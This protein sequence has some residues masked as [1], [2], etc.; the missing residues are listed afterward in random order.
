MW[1]EGKISSRVSPRRA[2]GEDAR[3]DDASF[4]GIVNDRGSLEIRAMQS[5]ERE[6]CSVSVMVQIP[7]TESLLK[8]L[9]RDVGLELSG[10][11]A[12]LMQR[13]RAQRGF[14]GEIEANFIPGSGWLIPVLVNA[15][16]L[17][18]GRVE[19]WTVGQLTPTLTRTVWEL[20]RMGLRRAS[21]ISPF[22]GI[23]F[24]LTLVYAAGFLFAARLGRRIVAAIDGLSIA[25][26]RVGRGD[27]S[28]RLPVQERDQLGNLAASFNEMTR[29]LESLRDK[30]KRN[31]IL[32]KDIALAHEVQEYL[33][34]RTLPESSGVS[35]WATTNA[36]RV[37]SGDLFDFM[38]FRDGNVGL[39]CADVSG[40]GL[41][42]ALMMSHLHAMAEDRLISA[43]EA[44]PQPDPA[45]FVESLNQGLRGRFGNH[46]YATMFYG[47]F[48]PKSKMLRYVNAGHC[49]PI[50]ITKAGEVRTLSEGDLPV[51]LFQN[52][53]YE[54][55]HL[56]LSK[57]DAVLV[58]TDGVTDA[59]NVNGEEFGEARL[60]EFCGSLPAEV[61]ARS[62]CGLLSDEI[63]QWTDG[64]DQFDDT[65]I[66]VLSV[67][68]VGA[69]I[70]RSASLKDHVMATV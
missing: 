50:W 33:Y 45:A 55:R 18:T 48:S 54:E 12:V 10:A 59:L 3:F 31:A 1:S 19:D 67:D 11:R 2:H 69:P 23:A 68:R 37:L 61:D 4:V 9:S 20:S 36:A 25:T 13:Y 53:R 57:G 16:N 52:V 63:A 44:G 32:E 17:E 8:R 24:G 5:V 21:W 58:Y 14:A 29:D 41:S 43:N 22:G 66:L 40:K 70:S 38:S 27:F 6:E 34:P 46:R 65:T 35:V 7:L 26:R 51:G 39:L 15:R 47:E 30:E 42:A 62:I 64:V 56:D 60:I 28:V 49:A